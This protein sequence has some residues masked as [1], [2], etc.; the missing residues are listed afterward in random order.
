MLRG[1]YVGRGQPLLG[2]SSRAIGTGITLARFCWSNTSYAHFFRLLV[3]AVKV[4]QDA[5]GTRFLQQSKGVCSIRGEAHRFIHIHHGISTH[6]GTPVCSAARYGVV[7]GKFY[8]T[9]RPKPR[10]LCY[11]FEPIFSGFKDFDELSQF[12]KTIKNFMR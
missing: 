5:S 6:F 7:I 12:Q 3:I 10:L 4:R 11:N 9:F 8:I 1:I 2:I